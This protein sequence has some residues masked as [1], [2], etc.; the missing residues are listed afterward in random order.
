MNF[1]KESVR[2]DFP[3]L[4][5]KMRGKPFLYLDSAATTLKPQCVIDAITT[6]YT[7]DYATVHRSVYERSLH[8]TTL[9]NQARERVHQF[10]NTK[11]PEEIVFTRGTTD[12]I[13]LIALSYGESVLQ[14]GEEVLISAS[15]HHSNLVPWQMLCRRKKAVLKV[16]PMDARGVLLWE[17]LE[18]LLSKKTKIVSI[19][20]V[21]NATGTVHPIDKII[22]LA[23]QRGAVVVIDGAQSAPHLPIDVQQI[24]CDFFAFSGHKVYGPTGIGILYAKKE[25]L[26]QMPP[27]YGGGDMI[28]EVT[29]EETT[30]QDPPIKFEA[31]T[32]SFVQAI[33][34]HAALDYVE[35]IGRSPIA[36]YEKSLLEYAT[37]K[38]EQIEEVRIIGQAPHKASVISFVVDQI[39]PLD[40][41]TLLDL[42]GIAIRTG[43]HCAQ[44]TMR[45][46]QVP[47]T[48]RISFGIYNTMQEIDFFADMLIKI[49]RD[50]RR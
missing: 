30:Y 16:V 13:N 12:S 33:G 45:H 24:D 38:L 32:P 29:F 35:K 46:F 34:L 18:R 19:A 9:Y 23:H 37:K 27:L 36:A 49:I 3:S 20:H 15:E 22:Q 21:A 4:M 17:D 26:E 25:L 41:G 39:H 43:H 6:F 44:P 2:K 5:E 28:R 40:I 31:G 7:K 1:P 11:T 42:E 47:G 50:L 14:E 10:L 8:A 48:C